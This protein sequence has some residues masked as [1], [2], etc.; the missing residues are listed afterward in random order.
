LGVKAETEAY[1]TWRVRPPLGSEFGVVEGRVECPYGGIEV[2]YERRDDGGGGEEVK[3][4]VSVP[5]STTGHL[6]LPREESR[7]V[8]RRLGED[9]YEVERKGV[10]IALKPGKY[11]LV[12]QA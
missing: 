7:V 8:V 1:R 3:M 2:R 6:L 4:E 9:G 10:R 12:L 11:E 5:T